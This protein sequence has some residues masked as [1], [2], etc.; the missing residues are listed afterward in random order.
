MQKRIT[1][2]HKIQKDNDGSVVMRER[3]RGTPISSY[4]AYLTFQVI[5]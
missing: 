3:E 2:L 4:H 5:V 1:T